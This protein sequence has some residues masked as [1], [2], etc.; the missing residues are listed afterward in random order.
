VQLLKALEEKKALRKK[1]AVELE[2]YRACDPE[3]LSEIRMY[4]AVLLLSQLTPL[5]CCN[6]YTSSCQSTPFQCI[7]FHTLLSPLWVL[8]PSEVDQNNKVMLLF[9]AKRLQLQQMLLTDGLVSWLL[10]LHSVC[11]TVQA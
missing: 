11:A 9:Q 5:V 1:L 6:P 10:R 4:D 7:A 3:T 8:L 2:Q